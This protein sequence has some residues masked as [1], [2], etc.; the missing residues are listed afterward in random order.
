MNHSDTALQQAQ[1]L[2][3]YEALLYRREALE[4]QRPRLILWLLA[5]FPQRRTFVSGF[6]WSASAATLQADSR[7]GLDL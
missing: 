5:L 1:D 4:R 3:S 2:M 7:H 6:S